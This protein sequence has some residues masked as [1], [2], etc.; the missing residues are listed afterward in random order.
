M[1]VDLTGIFQTKQHTNYFKTFADHLN[2]EAMY[3]NVI[4][5]QQHGLT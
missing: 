1:S 2:T 3:L 5:A 4:N